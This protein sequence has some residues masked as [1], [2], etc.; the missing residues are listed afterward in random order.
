MSALR[1]HLSGKRY[2]ACFDAMSARKMNFILFR[3]AAKLCETIWGDEIPTLCKKFSNLGEFLLK[4][5][6]IVI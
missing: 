3:L 6:R 4:F 1:S 5:D 2:R